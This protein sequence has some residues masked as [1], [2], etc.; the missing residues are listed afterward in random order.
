[1]SQHHTGQRFDLQV[2]HGIAL[3]LRE[4]ADLRLRELDI[5]EIALGHLRDGAL[6][7][8]RR[9]AEILRGPLVEL[10]RQFADRGVLPIVD[11]RENGFHG[12]AHLGVGGLDRARVHS[13]FEPTCHNVPP[14]YFRHGRACPGH[15]RLWLHYSLKTW[16]PGT[17]PGVTPEIVTRLRT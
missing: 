5:L 4:I 7:L 13:A 3:F 1:M 8:G 10:L 9:E 12:F 16:T 6:D 2:E 11:L 14:A 17:S 15:P